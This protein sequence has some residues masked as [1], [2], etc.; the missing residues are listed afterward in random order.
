VGNSY[1]GTEGGLENHFPRLLREVG[2]EYQPRT[3]SSIFW[4]QGLQRMF[5][6]EV[7]QNIK[8]GPEDVIVVTSGPREY[9]DKFREEIAAA[10][11]QMVVHM[12]WGRNPTLGGMENYRETTMAMV[13][14]SKKFEN[15]TGT[16][17]VPC[18]LV[19]YDLITNPPEFEDLQ[20]RQDWVFME[21]NIHQN[22]IGTMVNAAAHY[23]VMTGQSPVGLPMWDPYP[24]ELVHAPQ[25]RTWE[26]VQQWK[27]NQ[28]NITE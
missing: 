13:Q 10:D 23:A 22:H 21:Q 25:Q 11:K 14:E 26:V 9:L 6:E 17:V 4:G 24:I 1:I 28:L 5:T 2:S 19:Y 27:N 18:G 16:P 12:T 20:L 8:E 3:R 15:E 7:R